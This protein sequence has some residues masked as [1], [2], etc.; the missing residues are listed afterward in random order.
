MRIEF[1][2]YVWAALYGLLI[3]NSAFAANE[4]SS[5]IEFDTH[6][7]VK[8]SDQHHKDEDKKQHGVNARYYLTPVDQSSISPLENEFLARVSYLDIS[9]SAD[10]VTP[11][12]DFNRVRLTYSHDDRLLSHSWRIAYISTRHETRLDEERL[13]GGGLG[14]SIYLTDTG[15]ADFYSEYESGDGYRISFSEIKYRQIYTAYDL[16][17]VFDVGLSHREKKT[18][19]P[20]LGREG[21]GYISNAWYGELAW[22]LSRK[23]RLGFGHK[24]HSI[25]YRNGN[26]GALNSLYLHGGY[27]PLDFVQLT[28]RVGVQ[29]EIIDR[30]NLD[31][32]EEN[33]AAF[34]GSIRFEF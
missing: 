7:L 11:Q 17:L 3:A 5:S 10:D 8:D 28:F 4:F 13:N 2:R 29:R 15:K 25:D 27:A 30:P 16:D 24:S 14:L 22:Y 9:L 23:L 32:V 18:P 26:D 33:A 20:N 19:Y 1:L 12:D 31:E 34:D 6:Y 21:G